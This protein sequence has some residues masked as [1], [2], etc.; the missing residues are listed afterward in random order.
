MGVDVEVDVHAFDLCDDAVGASLKSGIKIKKGP[1]PCPQTKRGCP[2][3]P[4]PRGSPVPP[5]ATL[6]IQN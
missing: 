6:K 4:A 5:E 1:W 2:P 3:L